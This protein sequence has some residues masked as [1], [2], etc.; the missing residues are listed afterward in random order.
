MVELRRR[1]VAGRRHGWLALV[2]LSEE[3]ER[4]DL[5]D[6]IGHAS[7]SS[8]PEPHDKHPYDDEGVDGEHARP[9]R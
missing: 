4:V 5:L 1:L 8:E 6:K 2:A 7:P 3:A 9:A